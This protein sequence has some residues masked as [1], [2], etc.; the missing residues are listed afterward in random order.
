MPPLMVEREHVDFALDVLEACI[1]E[2]E[3]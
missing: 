3:R 1:T 2:V